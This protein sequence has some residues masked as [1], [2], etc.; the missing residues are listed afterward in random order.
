LPQSTAIRIGRVS[1]TSDAMRSKY[2]APT[3]C[4][5][6]P[7]LPSAS[8]PRSMRM[9]SAWMSSPDNVVLS[10]TILRPL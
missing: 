2:A 4:V 9:R 3:S 10:I 5:R 6:N 8:S 7:P 1:F